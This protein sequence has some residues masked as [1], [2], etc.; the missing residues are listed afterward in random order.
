MLIAEIYTPWFEDPDPEIGRISALEHDY[1][2]LMKSRKGIGEVGIKDITEQNVDNG[3]PDP[4]IFAVRA[5]IDPITL[6]EVDSDQ[7]YLVIGYEEA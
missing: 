7:K 1:W 6:N 4:N 5:I 3:T 2:E